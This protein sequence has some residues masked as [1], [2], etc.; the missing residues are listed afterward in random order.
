M[1]V[2]IQIINTYP[3]KDGQ[4]VDTIGDFT[5][6]GERYS[7]TVRHFQTGGNGEVS[8]SGTNFMVTAEARREES[9][10]DSIIRI[11][12]T[13]REFR[14]SALSREEIEVLKDDKKILFDVVKKLEDT[15][16]RLVESSNNL[17]KKTAILETN[18]DFQF[19]TDVDALPK[20][21]LTCKRINLYNL[22]ISVVGTQKLVYWD[23]YHQLE[24]QI[25]EIKNPPA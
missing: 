9:V 2:K 10:K 23:Y 3:N 14:I 24:K 6:N 19:H 11:V 17:S 1:D 20:E 12:S 25:N 18:L 15:H 5:I 16:S 22:A 13:Y 7:F 21:L 4:C 8:I